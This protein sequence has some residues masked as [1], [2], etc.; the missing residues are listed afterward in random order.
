MGNMKKNESYGFLAALESRRRD[1][2]E[3]AH[4]CEYQD[5]KWATICFGLLFETMP[6]RDSQYRP[7]PFLNDADDPLQGL[8]IQ[9]AVRWIVLEYVTL[10]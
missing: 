5:T 3:V 8:T 10:G 6:V 1:F 4:V 9:F 2:C 7:N